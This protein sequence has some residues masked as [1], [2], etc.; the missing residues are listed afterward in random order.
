MKVFKQLD[1]IF[2]ISTKLIHR[3]KNYNTINFFTNYNQLYKIRHLKQAL[4]YHHLHRKYCFYYFKGDDSD[5]EGDDIDQKRDIKNI[6]LPNTD[7]I[8][9]IKMSECNSL[10][11]IFVLLKNKNDQL[12]WKHIS[13]A[14]AM[15]R[16]L[17]IIYYRIY[18]FEKNLNSDIPAENSFE[19]I[20]T[21]IDFLNLLNLI[22]KHYE[23]MSIQCL[24]YSL[25]CLHKIGVDMHCT[26]IEKLSQRL[27]NMLVTI[28]L[29]QIDFCIL[30]RYVVSI[31]SYKNLKSVYN[32]K[33]IWPIILKKI[34]MYKYMYIFNLI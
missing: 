24:S 32:L 12:N 19:N 16:E 2:K 28:P 34:S 5:S 10:Q 31:A 7:D 15:I 29:E 33:N 25:L 20:V 8:L 11:D 18:L 6:I 1:M 17:Q 21:N 3:T 22:E 4:P 27:N 30:S 14:I 26:T 9:T 23:F 13:M